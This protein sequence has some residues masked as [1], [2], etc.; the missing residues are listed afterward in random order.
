MGKSLFPNEEV[1]RF[2]IILV[3]FLSFAAG[4]LL[5]VPL[6]WASWLMTIPWRSSFR[7]PGASVSIIHID[8]TF[9]TGAFSL[10]G[11]ALWT[12][13]GGMAVIGVILTLTGVHLVSSLRDKD[14]AI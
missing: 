14:F 13:L 9:S 1:R 2:L 12:V 6:G 7:H 8:L 4:V 5:C 3:G 10:S 11:W